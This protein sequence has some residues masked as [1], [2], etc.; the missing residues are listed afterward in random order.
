[1]RGISRSAWENFDMI[2]RRIVLVLSVIVGLAVLSAP[3]V[4]QAIADSA[5]ASDSPVSVSSSSTLPGPIY[6]RPT[7]TTKFR[8]YL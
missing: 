6:F 1:M 4:S 2:T 7:E 5:G 8:N 3:A